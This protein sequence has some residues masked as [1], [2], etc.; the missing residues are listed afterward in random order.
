MHINDL[1]GMAKNRLD[2]RQVAQHY[3]LQIDRAGKALCPFHNDTHP[4]KSFKE[5]YFKCF[6]CGEGGDVFKLAGQLLGTSKPIETL[7]ILNSDFCLG[8][9]I[10]GK[11]QTPAQLAKVKAQCRERERRQDLQQAFNDWLKKALVTCTSYAKL[12][13]DW[14]VLYAPKN[15]GEP[16]HPLFEESLLNLARIEYLCH[17]LTYGDKQEQQKFYTM[18]RNEVKAIEQRISEYGRVKAG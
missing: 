16:L 9:E 4:S 14:Q 18:C 8:L 1:F 10:D 3:G 13:R 15:E 6:S 7:K 2:I 11:K 5:Q 12:L 17:C